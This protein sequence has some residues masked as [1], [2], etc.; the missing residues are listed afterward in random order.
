M[1][2]PNDIIIAT[3]GFID[4]DMSKQRPVLILQIIGKYYYV[5]PITSKYKNKFQFI[6]KHRYC[7]IKDWEEIGLV[8][9]SWIDIGHLVKINKDKALNEN[10]NPIA[11]LS[12]DDITRLADFILDNNPKIKI[13]EQFPYKNK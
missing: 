2:K 7:K 1:V 6:K 13:Q 8:K 5:F 3:I 4:I 11:T 9:P 12:T 10:I